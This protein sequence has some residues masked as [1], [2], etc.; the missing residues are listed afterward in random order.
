MNGSRLR[1]DKWLWAARF[2]KT[3]SLASDA[4]DLGRVQLNGARIK[5]A[6]EVRVGDR[7]DLQVGE[8]RIEVQVR[9]L[10]AMRGPAPVARLLYDESAASIARRDERRAAR[11]VAPEPAQHL[12]GRPTKREGRALRRLRDGS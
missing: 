7:V 5:P 4:I 11:A 2:F 6:H 3:R 1:I 8:A 10:S 12:K 9:G